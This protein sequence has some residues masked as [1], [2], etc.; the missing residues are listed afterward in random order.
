MYEQALDLNDTDHQIWGNLGH[1]YYWSSE[2]S[3]RVGEVMEQAIELA[4][5]EREV[6]ENDPDLLGQLAGYHVALGNVE[7]V[8]NLLR[9]LTALDPDVLSPENRAVIA[10]L[11]E[12]LGDRKSAI[13]W[14]EES[15]QHGYQLS[16]LENLAGMESLMEDPR[17]VELKK[18]YAS[19]D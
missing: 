19:G 9:R 13:Y 7:Q 11:Y 6:R 12:R 2:D 16:T 10:H 18:K 1:A 15:L 5:Q 8:R 4:G 14:I 3:A 17:M